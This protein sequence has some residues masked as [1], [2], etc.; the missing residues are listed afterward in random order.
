[1]TGYIGSR[2]TDDSHRPGRR[3]QF[4]IS[5]LD[6]VETPVTIDE[7]TDAVV[8][9]EHEESA[10]GPT[11]ADRRQVREELYEVDLPSL[12]DDGLIT[13]NRDEGLL[14]P[15][16]GEATPPETIETASDPEP[17]TDQ[18]TQTAGSNLMERHAGAG[19]TL[20]TLAT[21]VVSAPQ[22]SNGNSSASLLVGAVVV[23]AIVAHGA[24]R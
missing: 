19:M 4:I 20:L 16:S 5:Y 18:V 22:L 21:L 14:G 17:P 11:E 15:Y 1:M 3:R 13:Y 6:D 2:S 24:A 23:A 12:A 10:E 9:W 7:L 8:D